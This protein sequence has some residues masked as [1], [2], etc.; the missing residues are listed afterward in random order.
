MREPVDSWAVDIERWKI[1]VPR[2][3]PVWIDSSSTS[4]IALTN[5]RYLVALVSVGIQNRPLMGT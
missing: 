3:A 4:E 1:G 5:F 2:S